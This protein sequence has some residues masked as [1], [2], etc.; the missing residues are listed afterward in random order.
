MSNDYSLSDIQRALNEKKAKQSQQRQQLV[1]S[2]AQQMPVKHVS[3]QDKKNQVVE[4]RLTALANRVDSLMGL[5]GRISMVEE[6]AN[7]LVSGVGHNALGGSQGSGIV[8]VSD[9]DDVYIEGIAHGESIMWDQSL[10]AFVPGKGGGGGGAGNLSEVLFLGNIADRDIDFEHNFGINYNFT[11]ITDEYGHNTWKTGTAI[12]G[13]VYK[14]ETFDNSLDSAKIVNIDTKYDKDNDKGIFIEPSGGDVALHGFNS[15]YEDWS[16]PKNSSRIVNVDMLEDRVDAEHAILIEEMVQRMNYSD[17]KDV[18]GSIYSGNQAQFQFM[19]KLGLHNNNLSGQPIAPSITERFPKDSYILI[20]KIGTAD[21]GL[22]K[23]TS[24]P[25]PKGSTTTEFVSVDFLD[26]TGSLTVDEHANVYAFNKNYDLTL[27]QLILHEIEARVEKDGDT[28]TG[29]LAINNQDKAT[30][31]V[32]FEIKGIQS[33]GGGSNYVF[34]AHLDS[35]DRDVVEY[36][37]PMEDGDEIV[38]KKYVDNLIQSIAGG[39]H[40]LG[41]IEDETP[42]QIEDPNA[43]PG[44][45]YI[46][47]KDRNWHGN[48]VKKGD[49]LIFDGT[50]WNV[51]DRD[52]TSNY[53]PLTGGT[54]QGPI[55]MGPGNQL[56]MHGDTPIITKRIDTANDSNF[57]LY[58]NGQK[59]FQV[60]D[61]V[62]QI[63]TDL[64]LVSNSNFE[65]RNGCQIRSG[66]EWI[67]TWYGNGVRYHGGMDHEDS[68]VTKEYVDNKVG[69]GGAVGDFL[70]LDGSEAM[71]GD[72]RIFNTTND[73]SEAAIVLK[74]ARGNATNAAATIKFQNDTLASTSDNIGYLTYRASDT[75]RFFRFSK[76]LEVVGDLDVSGKANLENIV[77]T[78]TTSTMK[79]L[80]IDVGNSSS[81]ALKVKGTVNVDV[82]D[83]NTTG[84]QAKL[85]LKG[86]R[87]GN[88][89]PIGSIHL[90]NNNSTQEGVFGFHSNESNSKDEAFFKFSHDVNFNGNKIKGITKVDVLD[91]TYIFADGTQA[92]RLGRSHNGND[93]GAQTQIMRAHLNGR[94]TFAIRGHEPGSNTET[95]IFYCYTNNNIGDSVEYKGRMTNQWDIVNKTYVDNALPK[96]KAVAT[97]PDNPTPGGLYKVGDQLYM[98]L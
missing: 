83:G 16:D 10:N 61:A 19:N 48:P 71:S 20:E 89:N 30:N 93:G 27:L 54:M 29:G 8:N 65:V 79:Y 76:K 84:L 56:S 81:E 82:T 18:D 58:R 6:T 49:W 63:F 50:D 17:A 68:I 46:F 2:M 51:L 60:A 15:K 12:Q 28:M 77:T 23:I 62:T 34:S 92:M 32:S 75:E 31:P 35:K 22:F 87:T 4:Q 88:T 98:G 94:R 43:N 97:I 78:G 42:A 69:S 1:E 66:T 95:D 57:E 47:A 37:G 73:N 40:Y 55:N 26:G 86:A 59:R 39:L 33:S 9:A 45:F 52:Q 67:M 14:R 96:A 21:Y 7:T 25:Q 13:G 44:D 85:F 24:D 53:L 90:Q 5:S 80:N 74:G 36:H 11:Q 91:D 41:E 38:N 3:E 64:K 70:P 72:L